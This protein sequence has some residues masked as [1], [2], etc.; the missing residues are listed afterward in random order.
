MRL[1]DNVKTGHRRPALVWLEEG[2]EDSDRGGLPGPVGP[3]QTHHGSFGNR[4]VQSL[5]RDDVPVALGETFND[6]CIR[7]GRGTLTG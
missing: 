3:E 6:Y 1:A 4:Q 2:G 5:N 7:H